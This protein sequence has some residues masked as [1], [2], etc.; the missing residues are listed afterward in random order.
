M[1]QGEGG[2][3]LNLES[4]LQ[5]EL[6]ALTPIVDIPIVDVLVVSYTLSALVD[7]GQGVCRG[8]AR[9]PVRDGMF[10]LVTNRH[11][12]PPHSEEGIFSLG[13]TRRYWNIGLLQLFRLL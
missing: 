10:A 13:H 1:A 7:H 2:F 3:G 12:Q 8:G 5:S 9:R 6:L 11:G 4:E